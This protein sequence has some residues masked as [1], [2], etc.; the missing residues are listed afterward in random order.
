MGFTPIPKVWGGGGVGPAAP[1]DD[2]APASVA[3][4]IAG[5]VRQRVLARELVRDLAVDVRQVRDLVGEEGAGSRLLREL[6][7]DELGFL[8]PPGSPPRGGVV[9]EAEGIDRAV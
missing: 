5:R 7:Q 2:A 8:E 6:T 9:P 1:N 3:A 4:R